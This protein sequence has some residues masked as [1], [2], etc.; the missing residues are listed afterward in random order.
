VS[1]FTAVQ[2]AE[3]EG[4]LKT[5]VEAVNAALE[6][7]KGQLNDGA[8]S[9]SRELK[10][11]LEKLCTD[12][13]KTCERIASLEQKMIAKSRDY[14]ANAEDIDTIGKLAVNSDE[15]KAFAKTSG[16]KNF[17]FEQKSNIV[18]EEG[19][20][21]TKS[22][23]NATGQNQPL[24]PSQRLPG[25]LVSPNR[26]LTIRSILPGGNISSNLLEY[27]KENVFTNAAAPQN[28]EGTAKAESNITF[29][30]ETCAVV[31][32][33]HWIAASRQV[34][35]DAPMLQSYIENRLMYGL[36]LEEEDEL[37]NGSGTNGELSGLLKTGNFTTFNE[38]VSP[39]TGAANDTYLDILRKGKLQ[40]RRSHYEPNAVI[41]HPADWD[42][43]EGKKDTQGRYIYGDPSKQLAPT[44]WGLPV[45]PTVAIAEGISLM[46]DFNIAAQL[47]DRNSMA[48]EVSRE[49]SDFFIKNM[50][51]ILCEERLA[52][53]VYRPSAIIKI[54]FDRVST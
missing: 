50:V 53:A 23:I 4:I 17:R 22:V 18:R 43:I 24:V 52:L 54:D 25:I 11:E 2:K 30:L 8:A 45:V 47:W 34:L 20:I 13:S 12:H 41:M 29:T 39:G 38:P 15:F 51:A 16:Q 36:K 48:I 27:A 1:E 28:G 9:I 19:L 33:A 10:A 46:A 7:A 44:I 40:L 26:P 42:K 35:D 3:L 37:L 49:H 31:T 32:I 5:N 21:V 6:K 14:S